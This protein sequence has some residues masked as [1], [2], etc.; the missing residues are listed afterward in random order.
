[1]SGRGTRKKPVSTGAPTPLEDVAA[2]SSPPPGS[3][4]TPSVASVLATVSGTRLLDLCRLFGCEV[5]DISG[6]RE[7]LVRKLSD[8]LSDRLLALLRELGRDELRVVC[9]RHGLDPSARAR[10]DLQ[11]LVL[12]A[13]GFDPRAATF[14][15]PSPGTDQLPTKGQIVHARHRQWLVDHVEEG[16]GDE[17]PLVRLV[18]LDDD[19]PGRLLEVLWS[20]E[21]GARV[22][23]PET[24]GLGSPSRLDAPAHFG[25]YLH[26]IKWS[27]VS[28][29]DA[30]L[31]QAPFRAGIKLMAHQ[32]TPLIKAL[33]LPR[34]NLFIADDV[35]LGKTIEAGLVLQELLLRQQASFVLVVC[36]A[37]VC[38]QWQGEM[39]RRFGL[40]FEVM[41]RQFVAYRRQ[42]RGF[43]TNPWSTHNRF[44]VS[45]S[46]LRRPEHR[47][48]L[49][50]HLGE[51]ARKGLLILD[52]AHVAAPASASKYA[53]DTDITR[54]IRDLAPRFD[55][56]LFLSATPHNGHSNSFSALLEIL[57]PARFTRGVPVE[58]KKDLEPIMVRRL[59]RD[60]RLLGVESFPRRLLVQ[61]ALRNVGGVWRAERTPYDAETGKEG[62]PV[63]TELGK[64]EPVELTIAS[65]L[66]RYTE[67]CAPTSGQGRLP[68]IHLQ[69]RLLS[70][71]EAFARTLEAH[72]QGLAK[73][74]GAVAAPD[75]RKLQFKVRAKMT[76]ADADPETHG[77]SDDAL[78]EEDDA[79][80]RLASGALPSPT[81]EARTLL[82]EMRALAEKA[83]RAPDAK[84][85]ALLA[86]IREHLC[87]AVG[88]G[89]DTK[90]SRN[91]K[92]D[93]VILFT[94]Y[95]DTKRY[96]V[97]LLSAAIAH[98]KDGDQRIL[99]F[100]G[101][102][103]DDTR[104]EVQRAFNSAPSEH[105][106]R[107]L[108]A[109]DAAREGVNLQAHC[110]DLFHIDIP[111]N[112][113]RLEQRN[114]RIDRTLQPA[115]EVRCHYFLYPDRT[116]DQVLATVVR[117]VETVQR[118]L[119]SLGAVLLGQL[120]KVLENGISK[121]TR[122]AV[123]TI[124]ANAKTATVDAELEA[125]RTDLESV[126]AEVDLAGRRLESSR[127]ALEVDP[128]SL[129]GVVEIGL[130]MA[131]A[132]SL[133][134]GASTSDG[135][136]TYRLPKMD[137]SWDVTLDTLRPPRGRDE[138]F[139]EWRQRLPLPVTF[140]PLTRLSE[141]AEQLHLAHP[142]VKRILDRFLA[143]GFGAHDLTRVTAVIAPDESVVRVVA[144][145]RLTL[146]GP[147]AARLHDQL[148]P[149]AAA[150]SGD[151]ASVQPYKDRATSAFAIAST[152]RLLAGSA[153][154]PNQT[155]ATRIQ[156]HADALF[157]ALWPHL[158]AE[159]DALAVEA[160]KGLGQRARRESDELRALLERQRAAIDKAETRLRQADLFNIQDKDQKRQVDLDLKH[161]DRRRNEGASELVSEPA[162]IEALY[163]L[164]MSRL[165]PVGLVVAWP[166][167]MT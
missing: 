164:R 108:V 83:R 106:V 35:G 49:L 81:D 124:G 90:A 29:A 115:E 136:P 2:S 30:T 61:L 149:I 137:R 105:P 89:E 138:A 118:E 166:E 33:E 127:R 104:D 143:Q 76:D 12:E 31:L 69:Q 160:R 50:H 44:I 161:L 40:R 71:P 86:W 155:I 68:F 24:Q 114:G 84:A 116:E 9:R 23:A 60:L 1:M 19:D 125:R 32:L 145:A 150:W 159:A 8:H 51:R 25:A 153:K 120:E 141:D 97:E 27:A 37:S 100:H 117:K 126:R 165:T 87:P 53:T 6:G 119:G 14:R 48:A 152:E 95:A 110:A 74:G 140:H 167:S 148:V 129:R 58:G 92:P 59:K 70:S 41:T 45:H 67:L 20:L 142:L 113:A 82:S 134:A 156:T 3:K 72:V 133:S 102:M 154:A 66:Q 7:R 109:T 42:E 151:A 11:T 131:G 139:W 132:E 52:E 122:V 123:E 62:A 80:V 64:G 91:W 57:D 43:G 121:K 38:L 28:A 34:A 26:A 147:G 77:L 13:A 56:R 4:A 93:R 158:E 21:L 157:R 146:F 144:F 63:T 101:G 99:Q 18:C 39:Q 17:S 75:Q 111:W 22:I 55:N 96:L 135:R 128:E 98:T 163:E 94:E 79:L 16:S 15:R 54:T 88:L 73:H 47:D 78:A 36:P 103:G 85:L 162:A 46:L 107:I 65:K 112:P 10:A 5:R 130:R